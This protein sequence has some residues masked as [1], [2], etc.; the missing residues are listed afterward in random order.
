MKIMKNN[1]NDN[2]NSGPLAMTR[3]LNSEKNLNGNMKNDHRIVF[4]HNFESPRV[5]PSQI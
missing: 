3:N 4:T 2:R 5:F 1:Q